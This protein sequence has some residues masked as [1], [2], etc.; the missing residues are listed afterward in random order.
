M[1][2]GAELHARVKA[3]AEWKG[4]SLKTWVIR[5]V[6]E[7]AERQEAERAEDERKRRSR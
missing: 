6:T 5:A 3:L 4:Q 7:V 2:L 1:R